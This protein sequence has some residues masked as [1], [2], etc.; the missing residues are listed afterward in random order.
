MDSAELHAWI[1]KQ[2]EAAMDPA[3]RDGQRRF[4][5]HEIQTQGVRAP[6]QRQIAAAAYRDWKTWPVK[7]RDALCDALW[8]SGWMEEQ[9]IAILLYR[10]LVRQSGARE[11]RLFESWID[12]YVDNWAHCDG[13][14]SWLLA[15]CIANEPAL[16]DKLP[17]WTLSVNRWKR[18]AAA[19]SF[20]QEAKRGQHTEA[21][22]AIADRLLDDTDDMV[23]KGTGWLLKEAYPAKPRE[24][25]TFLEARKHR[26]A[27]LLLRY[28]AEKM[29]PEDRARVLG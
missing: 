20:L 8:Q 1:K 3:F 5:R 18:R 28:A 13:V 14:S 2:L 10:R 12:R 23:Q 25:T 17:P 15:G 9:G 24:V 27:R 19:V 22:L 6:R 11:F 4:F 16:M 21:V 29:T 26:P 7:Q